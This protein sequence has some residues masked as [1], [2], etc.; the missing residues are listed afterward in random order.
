MSSTSLYL[1][2][3]QSRSHGANEQ[4]KCCI[5]A[6]RRS[7]AGLDPACS[8]TWQTAASIQW[9]RKT[10]QACTGWAGTD[11]R[12]LRWDRSYLLWPPIDRVSPFLIFLQVIKLVDVCLFYFRIGRLMRPWP[13]ISC[14]QIFWPEKSF[15]CFENESWGR[16]GGGVLDGFLLS[17]K[18]R[19]G[20]NVRLIQITLH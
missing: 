3:S 4:T 6:Q 12:D 5:P 1:T 2:V 9:C 18:D 19:V 17:K 8:Q 14:H 20:E 16:G 10:R 13:Q 7:V 15:K 11:D